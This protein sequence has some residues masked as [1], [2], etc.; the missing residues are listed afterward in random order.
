MWADDIKRVITDKIM[1][2]WKSVPGFG[3]FCDSYGLTEDERQTI[4]QWVE[5]GA[6]QG[7]PSDMP[8]ALP[9]RGE[10]ALGDPDAVLTMAGE[11]TPPRGT[12]VYR[13]FVLPGALD[14]TKYISAFDVLPGD[15][16]LVHHVLLFAD[17]KNEADKLDGKD[18]QPGWDCFCSPGV[19]LTLN[20]TLGGWAP[21]QRPHFLPEGIGIE[22]AKARVS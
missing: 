11:F 22:L 6:P 13:C 1:P 18:G 19:A 3:E 2:P 14:E 12:D 16:K 17:T 4:L 7:D 15:R 5:A 21:G 10:W 8:D 9:D 20:S